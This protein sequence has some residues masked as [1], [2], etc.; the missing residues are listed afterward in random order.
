MLIIV[1]HHYVVNYG[2]TDMIVSRTALHWNDVF[3]LLFGWGGKTAINGFIFITGYFMC[4]SKITV[5]KFCK[6][7]FEIEF[8]KILI[9]LIF[10]SFGVQKFSFSGLLKAVIPIYDIGTGF[11]SCFLI[12]F[13]LIPFVNILIKA[14]SERQHR[15]LCI[16]TIAVFSI[17]PTL[18]GFN[19]TFNYVE[20]FI[21]LY[22]IS[23]YVRLYPISLFNSTKFWAL[24]ASGCLLLSWASVVVLAYFSTY[25]YYYF[26]VDCNKVLAL[27]TA[28]SAFMFFKNV[29]VRQNKFINTVSS[30]TFGVLLIHANSD[31]MRQWLWGD[32]LNN[33][34]YYDNGIWV[35]AHAVLSVV[36]VYAVCTAVDLLRIKFLERPFFNKLSNKFT[37]F[38]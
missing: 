23:S 1:A 30:A 26:V 18:P 17:L 19:V 34:G 4:T 8:Y 31:A 25:Q 15:I 10:L 32:L 38:R 2:L 20:W 35:V 22:L 11:S 9:Y 37:F 6:L 16:F 33:L 29:K 3:L 5:K 7:F 28:F 12:F 14:M 13:C 27:A 21:I 36:G 24:A